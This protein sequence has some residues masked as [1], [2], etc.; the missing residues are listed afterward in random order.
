MIDWTPIIVTG[1]TIAA[2]GVG[3]L[4]RQAITTGRAVARIEYVTTQNSHAD[5]DLVTLP[6]R[7]SDLA[8]G[9]AALAGKVEQWG[10]IFADHLVRSD[11]SDA[12][13]RGRLERLERS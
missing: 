2:G 5:P 8:A 4:V 10:A 1:L 13:I 11:R 3:W 9:Q 6:D 7:I 12:E